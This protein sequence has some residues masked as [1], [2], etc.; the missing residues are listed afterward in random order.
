MNKDCCQ[1]REGKSHFGEFGWW[2]GYVGS[3]RNCRIGLDARDKGACES[4]DDCAESCLD[5]L[6]GT[7]QNIISQNINNMHGGEN[8]KKKEEKENKA[9]QVAKREE[10]KKKVEEAKKVKDEE[11]KKVQEPKK[12]E[13]KKPEESQEEVKP[14]TAIDT[15]NQPPKEPVKEEPKNA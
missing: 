4:A 13:E 2:D 14:V 7:R 10:D 15:N 9:I 12:E 6:K 1:D 5:S 3:C 8:Q 11:E